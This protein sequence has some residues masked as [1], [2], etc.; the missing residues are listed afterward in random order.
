MKVIV[1][2]DKLIQNCYIEQVG[3]LVLI[4]DVNVQV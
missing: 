2:A 1:G 3:L 4:K